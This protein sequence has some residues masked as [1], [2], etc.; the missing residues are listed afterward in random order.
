MTAL[1]GTLSVAV[2]TVSPSEIEP[3]DDQQTW[4]W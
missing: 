3:I 2:A 4:A 1:D